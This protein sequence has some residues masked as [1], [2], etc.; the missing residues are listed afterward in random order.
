MVSMTELAANQQVV[1]LNEKILRDNGIEL[2]RDAFVLD[3]GCG[4]G[5]HVY[6]YLDQ[7]Y[8]NVYGYDIQNFLDLRD[9]ADGFCFQFDEANRITRMPFPDEHFDFVYSY[10]VF[11]HVLDQEW[12]F[13]EIARVL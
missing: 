3:F 13:R 5:R 12:A 2:S 9:P 11:E 6:E 10:S 1:A 8:E 7:R 4:S